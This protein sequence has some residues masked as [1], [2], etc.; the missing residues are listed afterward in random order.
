MD[1]IYIYGEFE[2][3]EPHKFYAYLDGISYE[4]AIDSDF[5]GLAATNATTYGTYL[6]IAE[7]RKLRVRTVV[8]PGT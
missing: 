5:D 6:N 2:K 4:Q 8:P 7:K 3:M 1:G